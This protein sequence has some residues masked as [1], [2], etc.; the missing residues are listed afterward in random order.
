MKELLRSSDAVNERKEIQPMKE[1]RRVVLYRLLYC[2][3]GIELALYAAFLTADHLGYNGA[4]VGLKYGGILLCLLCSVYL[5]RY[6]GA[7]QITAAM[8]MTA[9][10]DL[11]LLVLDSNYLAGVGCFIV[12]QALYMHRIYRISGR[13]FLPVRLAAAAAAV[14]AVMILLGEIQ[15]LIIAVAVY[16]SGL[17][18]NMAAAWRSIAAQGR[19]RGAVC[20]ALGLTLFSGCDICVGLYNSGLPL[21]AGLYAFAAVGMW[22][23]YLPSQVL[24]VL[25]AVP[26]EA[27]MKKNRKGN[28]KNE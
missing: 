22:A 25:S 6:G 21:P 13:L 10:A 20:F 4:G 3:T 23:F 2:F 8:V 12:V 15:P 16:F 19:R 9:A 26:E 17:L 14:A 18:V 11:F 5:H 1:K 24:I 27:G 28:N 7:W